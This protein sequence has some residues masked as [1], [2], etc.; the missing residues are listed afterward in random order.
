MLF[1]A[2]A[3]ESCSLVDLLCPGNTLA[4][5][6]NNSVL[7]KVLHQIFVNWKECTFL[8]EAGQFFPFL[9]PLWESWP[10]LDD[11]IE[12]VCLVTAVGNGFGATGKKVPPELHDKC[13][14][15]YYRIILFEFYCVNDII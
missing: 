12:D 3:F 13:I 14:D 4:K 2:N 11:M 8:A 5:V 1:Y 7:A 15:F 9:P 10:A 6:A